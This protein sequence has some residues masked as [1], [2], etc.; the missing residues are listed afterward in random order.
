MP[1]AAAR[2]CLGALTATCRSPAGTP[3]RLPITGSRQ[4]TPWR[5]AAR[6]R[7]YAP[8]SV[9][10]SGWERGSRAHTKAEAPAEAN[11]PAPVTVT[12]R[13]QA[14]S[15]GPA[16]GGELYLR[17]THLEPE[18]QAKPLQ[19][20]LPRAKCHPKER[21]LP[22]EGTA[23]SRAAPRATEPRPFRRSQTHPARRYPQRAITT[24]R[25]GAPRTTE[26]MT[27]HSTTH[28]TRAAPSDTAH[29]HPARMTMITMSIPK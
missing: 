7:K 3:F 12:Y 1:A 9:R 6:G 18:R 8:W 13:L 11:P 25:G 24:L 29:H 2:G 17:P 28:D 10:I 23:R 19:G 5:L 16:L 14:R 21:S 4:V 20:R 22:A 26:M 15:G 27:A